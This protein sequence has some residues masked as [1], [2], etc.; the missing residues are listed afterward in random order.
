[1]NK[2]IP[3]R[4]GVEVYVSESGY[5][6]LRQ[7]PELMAEELVILHPDIVPNVLSLMQEALAVA[8]QD[9]PLAIEDTPRPR[10]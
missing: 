7:T 9:P 1:M 4:M 8:L 5:V 6:C 2:M 10:T 3:D